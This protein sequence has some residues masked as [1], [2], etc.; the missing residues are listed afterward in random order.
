MTRREA[1]GCDDRCPARQWAE[2]LVPSSIFRAELACRR[3][4]EDGQPSSPSRR[5]SLRT[6]DDVDSHL[7]PTH[8]MADSSL[9]LEGRQQAVEPSPAL[10]PPPPASP[11]RASAP[12]VRATR[13]RSSVGPPPDPALPGSRPTETLMSRERLSRSLYGSLGQPGRGIWHDLQA[14]SS[15]LGRAARRAL[16]GGFRSS[17]SPRSAIVQLMPSSLLALRLP[18]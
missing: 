14:V 17:P 12:T 8:V 3:G 10:H 15:K 4:R 1:N 18:V 16:P 2:R 9:A 13:T 5:S 11:A 7:L 6:I